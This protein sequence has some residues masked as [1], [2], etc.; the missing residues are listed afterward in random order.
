[1]L[2][3][4]FLFSLNDVLGKYLAGSYSA[5]QILLFRSCAAVILLIPVI[6]R[7]GWRRFVHVDRPRLQVARAILATV[8]V[9]CFYGAVR[10]PMN[11]AT[12]ADHLRQPTLSP[13]NSAAITVT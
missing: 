4:I 9:I 1:M 12:T 5:P 11:P 6:W 10:T 3:A 8:E 7:M 2:G 13:R